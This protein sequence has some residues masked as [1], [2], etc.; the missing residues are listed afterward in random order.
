MTIEVVEA[1]DRSNDQFSFSPDVGRLVCR[2]DFLYTE[3]GE[4]IPRKGSFIRMMPC[5]RGEN[6]ADWSEEHRCTV[7]EAFQAQWRKEDAARA[8]ARAEQRARRE[9]LVN[10]ARCKLTD[11]EFEAVYDKGCEDGR[12]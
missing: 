9:V 8:A 7:R 5:D 10:Q 1:S 2:G 4:V 3:Y 11:E 6:Y 12:R